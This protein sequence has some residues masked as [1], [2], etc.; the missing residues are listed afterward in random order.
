VFRGTVS[1][2]PPSGQG[3]FGA[4]T[5]LLPD[6][7]ADQADSLTAN[8]IEAPLDRSTTGRA[9]EPIGSRAVRG[10]SRAATPAPRARALPGSASRAPRG[11]GRG[12]EAVSNASRAAMVCSLLTKRIALGHA[13]NARSCRQGSGQG[14][15]QG[16]TQPA[17]WCRR[18]G[19]AECGY[20]CPGQLP[21]HP[22]AK[23]KDH[24]PSK[25]GGLCGALLERP[26]QDSN[27]RPTA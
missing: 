10:S 8:A 21:A 24:E 23:V 11:E 6:T 22:R 13:T 16:Q 15:T 7:L 3:C 2:H 12:L 5:K 9:T 25:I 14:A 26:R 4:H 18:F 20:G 27:L 17:A 1:T 19:P